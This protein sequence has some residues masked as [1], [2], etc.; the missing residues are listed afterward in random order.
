MHSL[1]HLGTARWSAK[2]TELWSLT[3]GPTQ[4]LLE[5]QLILPLDTMPSEKNVWESGSVPIHFLLILSGHH[6]A[7]PLEL[8]GNVKPAQS[9]TLRLEE[10]KEELPAPQTGTTFPPW[11]S[12]DLLGIEGGWELTLTNYL[13]R[14]LHHPKLF[15]KIHKK[16]HEWTAPIGVV[17]IYADPIEHVVNTA[18]EALEVEAGVSLPFSSP[19]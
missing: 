13:S 8:A 2:A 1:P 18:P 5:T 19:Y 6:F 17:S 11:L 15:K 9:P 16:H 7:S 14:L 10:G 3:S 12:D 4:Q